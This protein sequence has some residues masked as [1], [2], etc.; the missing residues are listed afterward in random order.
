MG[1]GQ[2]CFFWGRTRNHWKMMTS[3]M[4]KCF[5]SWK[6]SCTNLDSILKKSQTPFSKGPSNKAMA[7]PVTYMNG[8]DYKESWSNDELMLWVVEARRLESPWSAR[9]QPVH[10]KETTNILMMTYE[11]SEPNI[12][13]IDAKELTIRKDS[14]AGKISMMRRDDRGR[15]QATASLLMDRFY[16]LIFPPGYSMI[17]QT[18]MQWS[19]RLNHWTSKGGPAW[20]PH[21]TTQVRQ[22]ACQ[23]PPARL[24]DPPL[25]F[26][27]FKWIVLAPVSSI[28][29]VSCSG[30]VVPAKSLPEFPP[31]ASYHVFWLKLSRT[32]GHNMIEVPEEMLT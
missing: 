20:L 25:L 18:A 3:A 1:T 8:V 7:F 6:K 16:N 27:A 24:V 14:D 5:V 19:T 15:G 11:A 28:A 21:S 2:S 4:N 23:A 22:A 26:T 32:R 10:P 9:N 12:S 31:Q 17:Q 29:H 13:S 30:L